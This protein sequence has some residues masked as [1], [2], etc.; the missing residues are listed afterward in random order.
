MDRDYKSFSRTAGPLFRSALASLGF[1]PVTDIVYARE[2][3]VVVHLIAF[4]VTRFGGDT[5]YVNYGAS[6]RGLGSPWYPDVPLKDEGILLCNRLQTA[7][8]GQGYDCTSKAAF[9]KSAVEVVAD[10]QSVAI[11]WFGRHTTLEQV[12][13]SYYEQWDLRPLG[14]NQALKRLGVRHYGFM[15]LLLDRPASAREWIAE[16]RDLEFDPSDAQDRALLERVL[17]ELPTA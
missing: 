6:I 11:A 7:D 10:L 1:T 15:Q 4:Q 5:Y 14:G 16:A 2:Y 13:R 12:A 8:K 3:G 17:A 9:E